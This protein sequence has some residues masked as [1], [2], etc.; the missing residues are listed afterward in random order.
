MRNPKTMLMRTLRALA[1][2]TML[3]IAPISGFCQRPGRYS[4]KDM[5][6]L[7]ALPETW[8]RCWNTHNMD[9]MGMMLTEDVDFV[10]VAGNEDRGKAAAVKHHKRTHSMQ[11]KNSVFSIDSVNIKYVK[12]DLAII[13]FG[14]GLKGD[15][16]PD[17]TPRQ[18]RHGIFTWVTIRDKGQ[19]L[20]LAVSNVNIRSTLSPPK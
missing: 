19:W 11:F 5:A 2:I 9:S 12:P 8:V 7:Q 15:L 20:L 6:A 10:S 1:L 4:P 14:W 3:G 16:D 13:H 17:G 18:P